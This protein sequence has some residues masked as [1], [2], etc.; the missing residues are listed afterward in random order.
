M[1]LDRLREAGLDDDEFS[2]PLQVNLLRLTERR[3][4]QPDHGIWEMRGEPQFFTH[5]RVM[6]WAAFDRGVRAVEEHGLPGPAQTWRRLREELQD[7]IWSKGVNGGV[8][9]QHY[10]TDAVDAALLQIPHTGFVTPDAPVMLS[11]ME[12]IEREL[13][14]EEGLVQRYR[15]DGRDGLRGPEGRFLMCSFWLV[16][17]YARS[18]RRADAERLM[19]RLL[20]IRTDLGLLAEEYDPGTGELLGNMPQAFSHLALIRAARALEEQDRQDG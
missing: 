19:S 10:G 17:Q 14:G 8:F 4:G 16:E 20:D 1:A 11:T 15:T 18:G 13:V 5:G 2:W 9:V 12:R 3:L 6:M 7:E